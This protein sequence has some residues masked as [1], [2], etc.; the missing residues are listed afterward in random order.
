MSGPMDQFDELGQLAAALCEG[1]ITPPEAARLE[2]LVRQTPEAQ[3]FLLRY[4]QLHGEL[5]WDLAAGA[6]PATSPGVDLPSRVAVQPR[7]AAASRLVPLRW[8]AA[9]LAAASLLVALG[10]WAI[11]FRSE[12]PG[13]DQDA[14]VVA[15]LAS[16]FEAQWATADGSLPADAAFG[17]GQRLGLR[18]GLAEIV[19]RSGARVIVQGPAILDLEGPGAGFLQTGRVTASVPPEAVGFTLRTPNAT[20][21]DL[22][23]EFGLVVEEGGPCEIH[24][25]AGRVQVHCRE[26]LNEPVERGLVAGQAL[27]IATDAT[28]ASKM[29]ELAAQA[30]LFVRNLPQSAGSVAAMRRLVARHPR[31]IHH[32][33]LE[34]FTPLERYRDRKGDLHLTEAVMSNGRGDGRLQSAVHGFDG[35]TCAVGPFRG[36]V[37]GNTT[38]VALQ[39]EVPFQPPTELTMELLVKARPLDGSSIPPICVAV[40]MRE[41]SRRCSFLLAA[42]DHGQLTHLLD[43]DAPWVETE[44]DFAFLADHWHYLA[45]TFRVESGQTRVNTYVADLSQGDR[46][47]NWIVKDRLVPGVL[48]TSRLGIGKGFDQNGAHAYPWSGELDEVALYD[49]VLDRSELE[50]HLLAVFDK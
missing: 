49:A 19:F 41:D 6:R 28:G 10:W 29:D 32:Y 24:T 37:L 46:T 33:T 8:A 5:Y 35:T 1:E 9:V 22:G 13:D 25:F 7:K 16:T 39:S 30:R 4:V 14:A 44:S 12:R 3:S 11:V 21:L 47:L 50:Q 2:Q 42:V 36:S 26:G 20:V 18:T 45:S 17:A 27:R 43:A 40:A 31:L 15:R 23:T 34:G 38:G 48:A